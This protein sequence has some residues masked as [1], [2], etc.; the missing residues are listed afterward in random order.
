VKQLTDYLPA[1][2][3]MK[4]YETGDLR[5]DL[6]AGFTTAVMLI[7]QGM[8]YAMLA[9]LPPIVGLYASTV[10]LV[11]YALFG[12]SFR[13]AVGPVAM[14]S[15]L[16]A[17]GVGA[18]ADGGTSAYVAYAVLLALMVGVM[19]L[20]MG[21]V[22]MGFLT[23]FLSH[24]VLSGFTSAAALIIGFS[25]LKHL[26]GLDLERSKNIFEILQQ[27]L[28][29]IGAT[30][31]VTLTIGVGSIA[32]L[33]GLRKYAPMF[34][35]A[36][37]V[38]VVG[39]LAVWGLDLHA[40]AG[41]AIVRDVPAGLPGFTVPELS[42]EA[43]RELLPI[44]VTISLVGFMESIAV[45]KKIAADHGRGD[46]IDSNQ[47]LIGLGL[48][49]IGGAFFGGYPVTGGFSRTA[50]N[51]QAGANTSAA[52]I[53]TAVVI[54]ITLV[55]LTPLFYFLPRAVLAA[56]IMTA[57]FGLVDLQEVKH[58][59][60]V[61]PSDLALLV[62]TFL[63]T[64]L[65]GIEEGIL[66]GVGASMLWFVVRSTR[67]HYA[68]LGRLPETDTYR[69]VDRFPEAAI[70][71]GVLALRFDSEFYFGNVSF[72]KDT[73]REEEEDMATELEAIVL[74]TTNVSQLDS[75]ADTALRDI[76]E[77]Y[78]DRGI[79]VY[80]AG[81]KGPV[82]DI[83]HRSGLWEMLG[84]DYITHDVH[85]AIERLCDE[86]GIDPEQARPYRSVHPSETSSK[87]APPP[88]R[89]DHAEAQPNWPETG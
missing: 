47:E 58:L 54:G 67:P 82:R 65:V 83:M 64:L 84:D 63:A 16:T 12:T 7:P 27:A 81:T 5:G 32:L 21:L 57:V 70:L 13:L 35:R 4:D 24:P 88:R 11:I 68:V 30:D 31:P 10:P 44:A 40:T 85:T 23:N 56:I 87:H 48:A 37:A 55:F 66:I 2:G 43:I 74:D 73:L 18:L 76:V 80:F 78:H 75:S 61:K 69:N 26:M 3:W 59:W 51:E 15:L 33:L 25:Q 72:L 79:A 6:V 71:P 9:G 38:V 34:P 14:V 36:L 41:V 53:I 42:W 60:E 39:T 1:I 45:A 8:A 77:E 89:P 86:L 50:V 22:R 17:T 28:A 46:A 20:G 19:Q 62:I 52:G 29:Q 49:N